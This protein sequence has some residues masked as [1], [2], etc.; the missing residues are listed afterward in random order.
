M[1]KHLLKQEQKV[2]RRN[3]SK[4]EKLGKNYPFNPPNHTNFRINNIDY[5]MQEK[6]AMV[7]LNTFKNYYNNEL[8]DNAPKPALES[9]KDIDK[10]LIIKKKAIRYRKEI[11]IL[12]NLYIYEKKNF[13]FYF[14]ENNNNKLYIIDKSWLLK[15]KLFYGYNYLQDYFSKE[16][17]EN[18]ENIN[19]DEIISNIPED[20]EEKINNKN[21][22]LKPSIYSHEYNEI[23]KKQIKKI[24]N[25]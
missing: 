22:Y 13:K 6:R 24:I 14:N 21:E 11:E 10:D 16:N 23:I 4:K 12:L 15:Y 25:L 1:K 7:N 8:F 3:L 9:E 20:Y 18:F 17:I 19:F 5:N 2:N